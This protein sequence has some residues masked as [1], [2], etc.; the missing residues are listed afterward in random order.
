MRQM[1]MDF[2]LGAVTLSSY[3][4]N[5]F[6]GVQYDAEG[7]NN[8]GVEPYEA[9]PTNGCLHRP[10]DPVVDDQGSPDESKSSNVMYAM[11]G[12]QGHA[13]VLGDP[14][15]VPLLPILQKGETMV[16]ADQGHFVRLMQDG[17]I[18]MMTTDTTHPGTVDAAATSGQTIASIVDPNGFVRYGPMGAESFTQPSYRLSH[19]GGARMTLGYAGGLVP[20]LGSYIRF[21][22]SMVTIDGTSIT[23]GPPDAPTMPVAQAQPLLAILTT[24]E[25]AVAAVQA[26]LIGIQAAL[27]AIGPQTVAPPTVA[28]PIAAAAGLVSTAAG[29]VTT[30]ATAV[31]GALPLIS[32]QTVIG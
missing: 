16:Y 27:A 26:A 3:D 20:N 14:R 11:R 21:S 1:S 29:A 19:V 10:L 23:I 22:A 5:G 8:S 17:S 9:H 32:T 13:F 15:V 6:L 30:A 4:D 12:G 24:M 18:A 7:E 2:D 31:A 25:A 28:G